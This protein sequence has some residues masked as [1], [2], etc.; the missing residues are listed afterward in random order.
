MPHTLASPRPHPRPTRSRWRWPG[1]PA[2]P[3]PPAAA[4]AAYGCP[5]LSDLSPVPVPRGL[6]AACRIAYRYQALCRRRIP[7]W[8]GAPNDFLGPMGG[9]LTL[10]TFTSASCKCQLKCRLDL[11]VCSWVSLRMWVQWAEE[12]WGLGLG[13]VKTLELGQGQ[14]DGPRARRTGRARL[15]T[16]QQSRELGFKGSGI[17]CWKQS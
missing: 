11:E 3:W 12:A 15:G 1:P 16:Q 8:V 13:G 6:A 4:A 7:A 10:R 17:S 9:P 14:K 2:H 5:L